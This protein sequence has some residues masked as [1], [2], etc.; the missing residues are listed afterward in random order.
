MRVAVVGAGAIG[1]TLAAM[2]QARSGHE[3]TLVAR[4]AQLRALQERGLLLDGFPGLDAL[5]VRAV[6]KLDARPD[7][8]VLATKT[9]DLDAA[10]AGAAEHARG[11]RVLTVQNGLAAETIAAEHFGER[12]VGCVVALDA[13]FLEPG[14]VTVGSVGGLVAGRW[15]GPADARVRAAEALL[16]S[17]GLPCSGTDN[18]AGARWTKLLVNLNN[19]LP[20]ATGLTV[21]ELYAHPGVPRFA[22]R[23][24]KEGLAVARAE[25]VKLEPIPWT[26]PAL[27]R[28]VALLPAGLVGP[29][30]ARRVRRLFRRAPLY[31][32]TL[33]SLKRGKAT[34]IDWLNGEVVARGTRLGVP[35]PLNEALVGAVHAVERGGAFLEVGRLPALGR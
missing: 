7:W 19:A 22:A 2:L 28:A 30:L 35:T 9:Q 16:R 23:V 11:A 6:D 33:Q 14:C 25:G 17:A 1:C 3:V 29:M 20:A 13:T 32:S 24:L 27:L 4:G 15:G 8:L 26:S 10:A 12:V 18:F 21:Q 5:R 34:E 31:G